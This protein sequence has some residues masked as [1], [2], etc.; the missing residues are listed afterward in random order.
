MAD[1]SRRV[2]RIFRWLLV[3]VVATIVF[4]ASVIDPGA[5]MAR[6]GPLGVASRA[7]WS[8]LGAY[9]FLTLSVL[10][11]LL[12]SRLEASISTAVLPVIVI[13]FGALIELVQLT[14][15]YRTFAVGDVLTNAV[16]AIV[17]TLVWSLG[18]R[19]LDTLGL[20]RS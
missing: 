4:L 12:D 1:S 9:A 11:A 5:G 14:L 2:P 19:R 3:V 16:G 20:R 7:T 8:H 6:S 15:P 17:V 13:G 10:Y 18:R